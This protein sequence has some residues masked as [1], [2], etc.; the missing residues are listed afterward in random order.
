MGLLFVARALK[1]ALGFCVYP[2]LIVGSLGLRFVI[3][4]L[5]RLYLAIKS[6][7]AGTATIRFQAFRFR[8]VIKHHA[9][10]S[11]LGLAIVGVLVNNIQSRGLYAEEMGSGT[12][13]YSLVLGE[14][15][16]EEERAPESPV[17]RDGEQWDM[18]EVLAGGAERGTDD[19]QEF[20]MDSD[21]VIAPLDSLGGSTPRTR[22]GIETYTAQ[23]GDT[24]S[25]IA[26]QFGVSVNTILWAN[27][28]SATSILRPGKTLAILP[29]SGIQYTVQ[30]GDTVSSL[31][32]RYQISED[33]IQS[34]NKLSESAALVRGEKLIL[35]GARPLGSSIASGSSSGASTIAYAPKRTGAAGFIWPTPSRRINQ[36]FSWRHSGLD[37][38]NYTANDPIYASESGTIMIAGWNSGGYGN[39]VLIQHTG[40]VQTNY[41]HLKKVLVKSGQKV[42]KGDVIGIMG[43]TGRSTGIHLHFEVIINGKRL[44]PLTYLQ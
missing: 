12:I 10:A 4:P 25:S 19:L 16:L 26:Y 44:N 43:T 7:S 11:L 21:G 41:G 33:E 42:K 34:V 30:K 27:S 40:G 29:V 9:T 5:Y 22:E 32:K 8:F 37:I 17:S 23:D 18:S 31:A 6:K 38:D 39:R 35:S 36:Y 14:Q 15:E 1:A 3:V 2:F 24:I 13:L 28:L 20:A